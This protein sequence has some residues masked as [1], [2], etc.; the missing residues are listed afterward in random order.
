MAS[1]ALLVEDDEDMAAVVGLTLRGAG[2]EV[3]HESLGHAALRRLDHEPPDLV[4]LDLM[5]PDMDGLDV[6]R[7]VRARS[8]VPIIIITARDS[9]AD[10]VTGLEAGADDYLTKPFEAPELV[11]R[12]RA[13]ARRSAASAPD[14]EIAVGDVVIDAVAHRVR[15]AGR[16]VDLTVTEFRLLH[17]LARHRGQALS[18]QQLL[19][20]VW[21]YDHLGDS[22]VVDMAVRRLRAKVDD[23]AGRPSLVTTVR[24]VGYRL[25][26]R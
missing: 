14:P 8:D 22:R 17:E 16:D 1:R 3:C 26:R 11:A 5:L 4:V 20:L 10:V 9:L 2:L 13:L 25:D 23:D 24:G 18:R 15:K 7:R 6:C 19:T 21:G 12:A